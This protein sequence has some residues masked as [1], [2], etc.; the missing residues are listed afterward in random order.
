MLLSLSREQ[1]GDRESKAK[2]EI[3]RNQVSMFSVSIMLPHSHFHFPVVLNSTDNSLGVVGVVL[4]IGGLRRFLAEV[5]TASILADMGMRCSL[6]ATDSKI[7]GGREDE[8]VL[9]R[10][11]GQQAP[12]R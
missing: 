12:Q 2:G 7:F 8:E 10:Q 3:V 4:D 5:G 9:R 1:F 11:G 6:A